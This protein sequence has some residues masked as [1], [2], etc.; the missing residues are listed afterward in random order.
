MG[1]NKEYQAKWFKANKDKHYGKV[2]DQRIRL[3]AEINEYK[4][5][6]P[7]VDCGQKYAGCVMDFDHVENNKLGGVS[8][9][10]STSGRNKVWEEIA[11][12]ELVCANCHRLRTHKRRCTGPVL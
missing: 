4:E 3:R 10:I 8:T 5:N 2:K 12:C 9:L 7:C 6:N 1:N 11:K